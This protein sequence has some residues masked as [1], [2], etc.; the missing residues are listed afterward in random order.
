MLFVEASQFEHKGTSLQLC[1]AH[2][3]RGHFLVERWADQ[4]KYGQTSLWVQE[5]MSAW[6][7]GLNSCHGL[8]LGVEGAGLGREPRALVAVWGP[9]AAGPSEAWPW[10]AGAS[11]TTYW[12][13]GPGQ[14]ADT[15]MVTR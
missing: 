7:S 8:V 1:K 10:Q 6:W 12:G 13:Q 11:A 4:G 15:P 9:P 3:S 14:R 2:L 5:I